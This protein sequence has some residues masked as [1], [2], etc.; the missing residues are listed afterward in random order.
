MVHT[1]GITHIFLTELTFGIAALLHQ[2]GSCDRL[3]IL[4]RFGKIDG[5]I[6]VSVNTGNGP[7]DVAGDPV[8]A[9]IVRI[10]RKL[11]IVV[12]GLL[13]RL[14]IKLPEIS[15][16][17]RRSRQKTVHQSGIKKIPVNGAVLF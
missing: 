5:N 16:N 2:F 6:N 15:G 11:V 1:T 12:C 8:A 10:L 7:A 14:L 17:L 3:G 4:L 9:D 13:R